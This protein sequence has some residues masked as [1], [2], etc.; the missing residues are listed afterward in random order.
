[1]SNTDVTFTVSKIYIR[2]Q[3]LN[4]SN[5][6]V[7]FTVSKIYSRDVKP[8]THQIQ[9]SRQEKAKETHLISGIL[10]LTP[11]I[12]LQKLIYAFGCYFDSL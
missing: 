11:Y 4:T 9:A 3:T 2:R 10:H 1:M 5:T 8:K 7:M 12:N 6:G